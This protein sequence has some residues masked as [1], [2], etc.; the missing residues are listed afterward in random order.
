MPLT[1]V[2]NIS[3]SST[4]TGAAGLS[5]P[6]D[7]L[8]HNNTYSWSNG[9]AANQADRQYHAQPTLAASASLTLDLAANLTDKFGATITFAKVKKIIVKA[10]LGNTNNVNVTRPATN[11]VPIFLAASDGIGV[12]P[13][14]EFVLVAPG[15]AGIASVVDTSAQDI[16][17]TNSGAGTAVT[18]DVII[19]GTSA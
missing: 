16:T 17:F 1:S 8:D 19:E 11:G 6:S 5:R 18:F 15:L 13:G 7:S 12:P 9:V 2:L 3:Q 10:A 14:G 4:F